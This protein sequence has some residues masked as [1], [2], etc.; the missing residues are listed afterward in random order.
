MFGSRDRDNNLFKSSTTAQVGSRE[1]VSST[2]LSVYMYCMYVMYMYVYYTH[3]RWNPPVT[4]TP[5]LL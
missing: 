2:V 4:S 1:M 5:S 3:R